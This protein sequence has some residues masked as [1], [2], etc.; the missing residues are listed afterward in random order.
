MSRGPRRA[1]QRALRRAAAGAALILQGACASL[2]GPEY[3]VHDLNERLNR[4]SYALSDAVD[5][6]FLVPVAKSYRRI[7]PDFVETGVGNFF[8]NLS[9]LD[10]GANGLLQGKPERAGTDALRF[11]LNSTVG[12]GG[13]IDVATP[14]GLQHQGEDFGQTL[15]VWGWKNSR[16][17]YVPMLGPSTVRDLP[18][19]AVG[20]LIPRLLFGGAYDLRAAALSVVSARSQALAL[21][22]ARDASA[23]DA[24][25]FTREAYMQRR[26]FLIF[27][28]DPPVDEFDEFFDEFYEERPED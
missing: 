5:R 6:N 2:D 8:A 19:L 18:T 24:Y 13:L 15:A 9:S 27:D 17:V 20:S 26:N 14:A 7:A 12:L 22:E 11:L 1:L 16:F 21:T 28:G 4:Q 10:S 25:V 23:L 3:G